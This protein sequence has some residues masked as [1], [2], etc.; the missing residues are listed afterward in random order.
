MALMAEKGSGT[1]ALTLALHFTV[2][3]VGGGRAGSVGSVLVRA[4]AWCFNR[5]VQGCLHGRA[6][7]SRGL[8]MDPQ[9]LEWDWV[10]EDQLLPRPLFCICRPLSGDGRLD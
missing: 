5:A 9:L 7:I 10:E 2:W 3:V 6:Q 1:W 4:A 8:G